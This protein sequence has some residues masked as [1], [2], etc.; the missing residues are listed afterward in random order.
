MSRLDLYPN[1]GYTRYNFPVSAP[2]DK[3]QRKNKSG[4]GSQQAAEE[5]PA[6]FD[7]FGDYTNA[8]GDKFPDTA[9]DKSGINYEWI[10]K[11]WVNAG[12]KATHVDPDLKDAVAEGQN[13]SGT[14]N[15]DDS[16]PAQRVPEFRQPFRY[17]DL[18]NGVTPSDDHFRSLATYGDGLFM[19]AQMG[20]L[21]RDF[22]GNGW[23]AQTQFGIELANYSGAQGVTG[24]GVNGLF[25]GATPKWHPSNGDVSLY[26]QL[27]VGANYT[28]FSSSQRYGLDINT[29]GLY[30]DD[31]PLTSGVSVSPS[32]QLFWSANSKGKGSDSFKTLFG[33]A[34]LKNAT[35]WRR[36][37]LRFTNLLDMPN[38]LPSS[39]NAYMKHGSTAGYKDSAI[40]GMTFENNYGTNV[41]FEYWN[42][43]DKNPLLNIVLNQNV[44]KLSKNGYVNVTGAIENALDTQRRGYGVGIGFNFLW[45]KLNMIVQGSAYYTHTQVDK[46]TE[47]KPNTWNKDEEITQWSTDPLLAPDQ[48]SHDIHY[49]TPNVAVTSGNRMKL[50]VGSNNDNGLPGIVGKR[51][52]GTNI[53]ES[54]TVR[55]SSVKVSYISSTDPQHPR[56]L[57]GAGSEIVGADLTNVSGGGLTMNLPIPTME[58]GE[59]YVQYIIQIKLATNAADLDSTFPLPDTRSCKV[60][61]QL[62]RQ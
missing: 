25:K 9:T 10:N 1:T 14:N 36:Y 15:A 2:D 48:L 41:N 38:Y 49:S 5:K 13:G 19:G 4:N 51:P 61:M 56:E 20:K 50:T 37:N 29:F 6:V 53:N 60:K 22:G 3:G 32:V 23:E 27:A 31:V 42:R 28:K 62:I 17:N 12:N 33:A 34:D 47:T 7:P 8:Y 44:L 21:I 26:S 58:G 54:V 59:G 16:K 11:N 52:D 40:L 24:L 35:V 46:R 55:V 39:V 43:G 18:N 45:E 57:P 30:A